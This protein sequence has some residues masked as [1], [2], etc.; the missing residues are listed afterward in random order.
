MKKAIEGM[1]PE[2][3]K[4]FMDRMTEMTLNL[5]RELDEIKEQ[6]KTIVSHSPFPPFPFSPS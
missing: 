5:A 3:T 2:E 6:E 4:E 1:T